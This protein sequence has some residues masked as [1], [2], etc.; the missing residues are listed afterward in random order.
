V[1]IVGFFVDCEKVDKTTG[2]CKIKSD[3]K[4]QGRLMPSVGTVVS[5]PPI[6]KDFAFLKAMA[7]IR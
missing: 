2:N 1:N 4:F 7:I 3:G 5:G 6:D